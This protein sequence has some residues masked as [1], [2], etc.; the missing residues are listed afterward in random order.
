M[1]LVTRDEQS[2]DR[3]F[4]VPPVRGYSRAASG[5]QWSAFID[6]DAKVPASDCDPLE[7][8]RSSV[9]SCLERLDSLLVG[10]K[11]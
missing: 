6:G 9:P 2:S 4:R 1:L 10:V 3:A 11:S 8:L 5:R 7:R